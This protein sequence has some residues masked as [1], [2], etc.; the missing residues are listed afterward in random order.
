[1]RRNKALLQA[2]LFTTHLWSYIAQDAR[3]RGLALALPVKKDKACLEDWGRYTC[4]S[5]WLINH[6]V[7]RDK[8]MQQ[9]LHLS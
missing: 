5:D 8:Y 4:E 6:C 1:M 7:F 2:G 3:Y 9:R